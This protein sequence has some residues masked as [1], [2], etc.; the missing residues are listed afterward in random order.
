M[1]GVMCHIIEKITGNKSYEKGSDQFISEYLKKDKVKKG[2]QR[3]AYHRYHHQPLT[4]RRIIVMNPVKHKM[5][6]FS[7]FSG[8]LPVKNEAMKNV[9]GESPDDQPQ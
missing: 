8:R 3:N 7:E 1:D 9:L 6:S 2:C 5:N 4:V